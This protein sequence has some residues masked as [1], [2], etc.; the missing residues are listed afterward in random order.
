MTN[1]ICL[2]DCLHYEDFDVRHNGQRISLDKLAN[3]EMGVGVVCLVHVN[4]E[5]VP[6]DWG[7]VIE[8]CD[9]VIFTALAAGGDGE[10]NKD[11]F[12]MIA[13]IALLAAVAVFS[14]GLGAGLATATGLAVPLATQIVSASL[15][16]VG[17][18]AINA[19]FPASNGNDEAEQFKQ[20]SPQNNIARLK[21]PIAEVF[22]EMLVFPD[23][24]TAP[25]TRFVG[26]KPELN[27]TFHFTNGV[28]QISAMKLGKTKISDF[29]DLVVETVQDGG[30]VTRYELADAR[31]IELLMPRDDGLPQQNSWGADEGFTQWF[32]LCPPHERLNDDISHNVFELSLS[33]TRGVGTEFVAKDSEVGAVDEYEYLGG[34]QL[35]WQQVDDDGFANGV[36]GE[37]EIKVPPAPAGL[38]DNEAYNCTILFVD[39]F[40]NEQ[41]DANFALAV[42][43]QKIPYEFY[44]KRVQ[45]RLK[46]TVEKSSDSQEATSVSIASLAGMGKH[47]AKVAGVM[48]HL[49]AG[50][51]KR[52]PM[53]GGM[54]LNGIVR[55]HVHTFEKVGA[56]FVYGGVKFA[57]TPA[58]IMFHL[59]YEHF[60]GFAEVVRLVDLD[61]LWHLHGMNL[62]LGEKFN[63][64]IT[65]QRKFW[66]W[67]IQVGFGMRVKPIR[68]GAKIT[69]I[70][71]MLVELPN[72]AVQPLGADEARFKFNGFHIVKNSLNVSYDMLCSDDVYDG[73]KLEFIDQR[74]WQHNDYELAIDGDDAPLNPLVIEAKGVTDLTTIK[75]IAVHMV[76]AMKF[77]RT[78]VSFKTE[79]DG[80]LPNVGSM[81]YL[82]HGL[83]DNGVTAQV[84]N[85]YSNVI[86]LD[87]PLA[88]HYGF[89][90]LRLGDARASQK[91]GIRIDADMKT[92]RLDELPRVDGVNAAIVSFLD[93][94]EAADTITF[95]NQLDDEP[96][97]IKVTNM[98]FGKRGV[99]ISGFVD[100]VR[101]YG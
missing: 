10:G 62:A 68:R 91:I 13:Q 22:G 95:Y 78:N 7:R 45:I 50:Q 75:A 52:L 60:G 82:Q 17:N 28:A 76:K 97:N 31:G 4:G 54:I 80:L 100:D 51:M 61:A 90:V 93:E 74:I 20:L 39:T 9:Q 47:V 11:G 6:D 14:G 79:L 35:Y 32:D 21:Q 36:S 23:L 71:D 63:A 56:G 98:K 83:I 1:V 8:P 18:L 84:F 53:N 81:I 37:L 55:R 34:V 70:R 19:L 67:L 42:G 49:T 12:R 48:A 2:R 96:C 66:D 3:R 86:E 29:S 77:R 59:L 25:Y 5:L 69:F 85:H 65:G 72:F 73:V 99:T 87:E 16:F 27:E 26:N 44:D 88:G 89:A 92:I 46:R 94:P 15:L 41:G 57:N 58:M 24:L 43:S 101:V 38:G 64:R 33:F 30:V 40:V